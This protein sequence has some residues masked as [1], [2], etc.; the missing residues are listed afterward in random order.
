MAWIW[1]TPIMYAFD[2]LPDVICKILLLNP[3]TLIVSS[4]HNILY[5]HQM[6]TMLT[7]FGSLAEGVVLLLI[8]EVIFMKLEGDF[9]EEL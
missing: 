7:M 3:M 6:P 4:Y 5:Y 2:T 9:A 1:A 8:G